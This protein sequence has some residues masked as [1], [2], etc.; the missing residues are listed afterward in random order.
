MKNQS[1]Y[2][3]HRRFPS[4]RESRCGIEHDAAAWW[5]HAAWWRW[6]EHPCHA[7]IQKRK[8][9]TWRKRIHHILLLMLPVQHLHLSRAQVQL[10]TCSTDLFPHICLWV[11]L[12]FRAGSAPGAWTGQ[13]PSFGLSFPQHTRTKGVESGL[14]A[15]VDTQLYF[16]NSCDP[17]V[18]MCEMLHSANLNI[19]KHLWKVVSLG[20]QAEVVENVLLHGVQVGIFHLDMLPKSYNNT[21]CW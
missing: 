1:S 3:L 6:K 15:E 16:P 9:V 5:A 18:L 20:A 2:Q 17:V 7:A 19:S 10:Y 21:A 14:G 8:R 11:L 13:K 12:G 4:G